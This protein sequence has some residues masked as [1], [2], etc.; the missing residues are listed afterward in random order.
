MYKDLF[1]IFHYALLSKYN[2]FNLSWVVTVCFDL[3]GDILSYFTRVYISHRI[4]IDEYSYLSSCWE[5]VSF[6]DT[7]KAH[8]DIL[9]LLDT[10]DIVFYI[11]TTCSRSYSRYGICY[12]YD[13]RLDTYLRDVIMMSFD[14]VDDLFIQPVFTGY[15]S[16]DLR[17]RALDIM[18]HSFPKVMKKSSF[19]CKHWICTDEFCDRFSDIGDFLGVHEDILTIT[20]TESKFP[21]KRHDLVRYTDDPHFL[22]GLSTEVSDEL[23]SFLLIFLDD[24]FYTSW[25]DTLIFYEIFE[26]LLRDIS[27]EK[28]ET[29][30]K[31]RIRSII[32]DEWYPSS[33]FKCDDVTTFFSYKFAFQIIA[34]ESDESLGRL[35]TY[36]SSVLLYTFDNNLTSDIRFSW[37]EFFFLF[38]EKSEDILLIAFLGIFHEHIFGIFLREFCHFFEFSFELTRFFI[39]IFEFSFELFLF[40]A[41][42]FFFSIDFFRFLVDAFFFLYETFF[43]LN[44]LIFTFFEIIFCFFCFLSCSITSFFCSRY[45]HFCFFFRRF[46]ERIGNFRIFTV[47]KEIYNTTT[48]YSSKD[49]AYENVY[50]HKYLKLLK[51]RKPAFGG[52]PHQE[53]MFFWI[54]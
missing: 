46:E 20:R 1:S 39:S 10:L 25:L 23:I 38:F 21:Y 33:F 4:S 43:A 42:N 8:S 2:H 3:R 53:C 27:A 44:D 40:S 52:K 29:W 13:L 11:H 7:R 15:A 37:F 12:L 19:E 41:Q 54:L 49:E 22:Y 34:F 50:R 31:Y 51:A 28:I 35:T 16:T 48:K 5:S 14:D 47:L 30:E 36:F 6:V 24:F 26:R 18:I 17:M 45:D 9:H 32:D